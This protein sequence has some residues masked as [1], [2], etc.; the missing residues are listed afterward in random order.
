MSA[1]VAVIGLGAMGKPIALNLIKAG[2]TVE[3]WNRTSTKSEEV[4]SQGGIAVTELSDISAP[5]VLTLLPDIKEL[6]EVLNLGLRQ[7]LKKDSIVVVMGTTS[8]LAV[9]KLSEELFTF[10]IHIVDAPV[11]GGDVGAQRGDLSIMVGATD[12]DF[13]RIKPL[14]SK[15]GKTIIHVGPIGSGQTLK[16]CNQLIV[17]ANF[18]AIAEALTMARKSGITDDNFYQIIAHGLAGSKAL[19]VK[20]EK[21][22]SGDFTPG[23]KSLF[24]LRDLGIAEELAASLGLTLES[25][26][27]V[28]ELYRRLIAM[29]QGEIDHSGVIK[30]VE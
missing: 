28:S 12:E 3:V 27:T 21:L 22:N 20:W 1:D 29:G 16:A 5:I 30:A 17:G 14:I 7:T 23:G 6:Y 24:Q 4:A 25:L 11:S 8:P 13:L 9:K 15:I 19:D 10:G 26:H 2:F 18:V